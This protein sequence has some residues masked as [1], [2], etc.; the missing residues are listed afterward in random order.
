[1][2]RQAIALA[3]VVWPKSTWRR[4]TDNGLA[5]QHPADMSDRRRLCR[6]VDRLRKAAPPRGL[7]RAGGATLRPWRRRPA[8][9]RCLCEV[10]RSPRV[11]AC[12]RSRTVMWGH[13]IVDITVPMRSTETHARYLVQIVIAAATA[14]PG[15]CT[16]RCRP[17]DSSAGRRR[18]ARGAA[19]GSA[20]AT[21]RSEAGFR[22]DVLRDL[23]ATLRARGPLNEARGSRSRRRNL[24]AR[25]ASA[26]RRA[27]ASHHDRRPNRHDG[28]RLPPG[29]P[30]WFCLC[31]RRSRLSMADAAGSVACAPVAACATVDAGA[32][33]D[34]HRAR[35]THLRAS[36][37]SPA[38]HP[39]RIAAYA[40]SASTCELHGAY[41]RPLAAERVVTWTMRDVATKRTLRV[42]SAASRDRARLP[43]HDHHQ[44]LKERLAANRG[45]GRISPR[46]D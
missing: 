3:R 9:V 45:R 43:D 39:S 41:L 29:L 40:Q 25:A 42:G 18:S 26:A 30:C 16:T 21:G 46:P 11:I 10:E 8:A 2:H 12:A 1:M 23:A 38:N 27:E 28:G 6:H 19:V 32:A 7:L 5:V 17:R 33:A 15:R 44:Q 35:L 4:R 20:T 13:S 37:L 34:N 36:S 14:P 22:D 31:R 24:L